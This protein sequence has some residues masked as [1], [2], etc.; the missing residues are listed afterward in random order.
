MSTI[1]RFPLSLVSSTSAIDGDGD[2]DGDGDEDVSKAVNDAEY[3][4]DGVRDHVT[5]FKKR[6]N[7]E[8]LE[9]LEEEDL[10]DLGNRSLGGSEYL[11]RWSESTLARDKVQ[12]GMSVSVCLCV[13][14]C[15]LKC[16]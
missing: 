16:I 3:V 10:H 6:Q 1:H 5:R 2:G 4:E 7:S 9:F 11:L 13:C 8:Q 15:V 14:L 12:G